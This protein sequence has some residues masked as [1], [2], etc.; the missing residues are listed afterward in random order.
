MDHHG[1]TFKFGFAKV[2][3]PVIFERFV[4]LM[5]KIY[6]LSHNCAISIAAILQ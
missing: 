5:T 2:C 1:L 6:V 4:S 3:S